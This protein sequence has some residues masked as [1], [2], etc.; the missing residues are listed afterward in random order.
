MMK[1]RIQMRRTWLLAWALA[2]GGPI[3]TSVSTARSEDLQA[4]K[5]AAHFDWGLNLPGDPVSR[6]L[7][8]NF[9]FH[10]PQPELLGEL[11]GPGCIRRLWVTG[12]NVGREV[13]LRITFDGESVPHVEA[14][15]SDF[16]GVMHN[17]AK[18]GEPY[19]INT[20]FI[21]VKPKNGFTCFFPMPFARSARVEVAGAEESTNLY[22]MIDWHEYP[23]QE[24][25]EPMRFC[26]RW[27]R[28]A[29]VRD[30]KDDFIMLD[31]DGPGRLAGFAYS[32]D[33]LQS[34]HTM[35]W[36]HAGADNIYLDGGGDQPAFLR[37][38]GGEDTFGTS[39]G[40]GDYQPQSALFADMPYFIQKDAAADMQKLAAYR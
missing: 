16:F 20:P 37:G 10:G 32:V 39:F 1:W 22:Y 28:E 7:S 33:M 2:L 34:R 21:D 40:G 8:R 31:A 11:R 25:A 35:R 27:R 19:V 14:P 9:K 5:R 24:L 26:A 13:V 18:P 29:P 12:I 6:R 23:G 30:H 38:I 17:L 15:L 3:F 36:S 4:V